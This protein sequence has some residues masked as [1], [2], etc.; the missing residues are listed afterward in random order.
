MQLTTTPVSDKSKD[1]LTTPSNTSVKSSESDKKRKTM[2]E[3]IVLDEEEVL[4]EDRRKKRRKSDPQMDYVKA[5]LKFTFK[6]NG[7]VRIP[8]SKKRILICVL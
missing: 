5:S 4:L 1:S 8:K 3:P 2:S 6:A 7:R